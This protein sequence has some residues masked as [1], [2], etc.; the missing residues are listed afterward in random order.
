M[1]RD[2]AVKTNEATFNILFDVASKSGILH[3]RP[4]NLLQERLIFLVPPP[5]L[6]QPMISKPNH[7]TQGY[8]IFPAGFQ[9]LKF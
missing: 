1:E 9:T 2:V 7:N 4:K 8:Q 3:A 6:W 5:R